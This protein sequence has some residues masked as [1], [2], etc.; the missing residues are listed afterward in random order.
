MLDTRKLQELDNHYDQ[1][2]RKIHHSIEELEDAFRL[3][4]VRTDKLR[5]TVYQMALSQGC[6]L[7]Q[8]AQMYLYQMEHNQDAFLVEF[9]AHMDELEEK[10]IQIRKDYDNQVDHLYMEAQRQASNEERTEI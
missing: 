10:Q 5:E 3:F 8:E 6:E 7:P 4:M 2:I 9:N 1:E